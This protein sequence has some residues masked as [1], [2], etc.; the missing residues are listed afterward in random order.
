MRFSVPV[1]MTALIMSSSVAIGP[2][3][4]LGLSFDFP[5]LTWPVSMP[6][7]TPAQPAVD[8][9]TGAAPDPILCPAPSR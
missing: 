5:T 7:P 2:A 4:A 8:C 3:A 9:T 6:A 1:L